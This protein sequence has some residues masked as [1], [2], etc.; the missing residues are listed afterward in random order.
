MDYSGETRFFRLR[1]RIP[2]ASEIPN[3]SPSDGADG[4]AV[5]RETVI[6]FS[7]PI[8]ED[9]QLEN[10]VVYAEFGRE[11]LATRLQLSVDRQTITLFYVDSL[12]GGAAC[13]SYD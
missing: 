4:I 2:P 9:T 6:Q 7:T 8:S 13:Y 3:S 1:K 10:D 5:P 11:R 12:P